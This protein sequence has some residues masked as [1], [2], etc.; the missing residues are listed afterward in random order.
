[1]E[2]V[3]IGIVRHQY[4]DDY[5]RDN[6]GKIGGVV[7]VYTNYSEGLEGMKKYRS[8]FI[9]SIMS[10][11]LHEIQPLKVKPR[12]LLRKGYKLEDLPEIGVF[13]T[14]S[15]S[16]PNPIALTLVKIEKIE[17]NIIHVYGLD[18]F[19]GTPVADIKP[20]TEGYLERGVLDE[21]KDLRKCPEI[22]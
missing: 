22:E 5:V 1:M 7:E 12:L 4:S 9:I 15:P 21:D 13:A 10:K 19:N 6:M 17:G 2:L 18:L 3:E 11:H 16:R 14:D 20:Y 8:I